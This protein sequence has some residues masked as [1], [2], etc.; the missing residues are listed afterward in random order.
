M[1]VAL[2]TAPFVPEKKL[3][4]GDISNFKVY[5][6]YTHTVSQVAN[7]LHLTNRFEHGLYLVCIRVTKTMPNW[8]NKMYRIALDL[9]A[10]LAWFRPVTVQVQ[11]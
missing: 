4:F 6:R 2:P 1:S 9:A 8:V 7:G 11:S 5:V 10:I 3:L